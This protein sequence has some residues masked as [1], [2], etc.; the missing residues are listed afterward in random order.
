MNFNRI[1]LVRF[2]TLVLCGFL[3]ASNF[4]LIYPNLTGGERL[5]AFGEDE[6]PVSK[7]DVEYEGIASELIEEREKITESKTFPSALDDPSIIWR[8]IEE[9]YDFEKIISETNIENPTQTSMFDVL[10]KREEASLERFY[11]ESS[12]P[13]IVEPYIGLAPSISKEDVIGS[14]DRSYISSFR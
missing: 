7:E 9:S 6:A 5:N 8:P 3:I 10:N 11:P 4:S 12:G 13:D 1:K 14:D 2:V